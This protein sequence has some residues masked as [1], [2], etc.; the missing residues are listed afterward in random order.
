MAHRERYME[1]VAPDR[2][3]VKCN[4]CPKRGDPEEGYGPGKVHFP[5]ARQCHDWWRDHQRTEGHQRLTHARAR[6]IAIDQALTFLIEIESMAPLNGRPMRRVVTLPVGQRYRRTFLKPTFD[7]ER[8]RTFDEAPDVR[9]HERVAKKK[10]R[11][12]MT[13]EQ[14]EAWYAENYVPLWPG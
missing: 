1:R 12:A 6:E 13:P 11:T 14:R 5:T 3:V 9:R 10:L 2:W 8:S 4:L 7:P